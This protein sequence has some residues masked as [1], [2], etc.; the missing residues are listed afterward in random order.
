MAFGPELTFRRL[1]VAIII[2]DGN[3][4]DRD[5]ILLGPLDRKPNLTLFRATNMKTCNIPNTEAFPDNAAKSAHDCISFAMVVKRP[6]AVVIKRFLTTKALGRMPTTLF[7]VNLL[8]PG[9][10]PRIHHPH[11][12]TNATITY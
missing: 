4:L 9:N 11:P 10:D 2:S 1:A 8:S 6:M 12:H 5:P 7:A 3:N